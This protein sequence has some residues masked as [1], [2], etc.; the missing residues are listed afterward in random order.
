MAIPIY[1]IIRFGALVVLLIASLVSL[2]RAKKKKK[3]LFLVYLK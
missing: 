3:I 2:V 1:F